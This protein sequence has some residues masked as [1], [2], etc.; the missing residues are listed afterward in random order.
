MTTIC[1]VVREDL[2]DHLQLDDRVSTGSHPR[3]HEQVGDVLEP[4]VHPIHEVLGFTA[5][6][7]P[8]TNDYF[9]VLSGEDA[10]CVLN[11][12]ENLSHAQCAALG[13]AIKYDTVH[14]VRTQNPRPLLTDYP[15]NGIHD[16]RLATTVGAYHNRDAIGKIDGRPIGEGL[17]SM[18]LKLA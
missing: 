16:V 9:A 11:S 2:F 4:T 1:R 10:A 15:A 18:Q 6:E 13:G 3:I 5:S 17:E 8:T 7:Q 12:E 14:L